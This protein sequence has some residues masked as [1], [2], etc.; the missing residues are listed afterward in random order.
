[1]SLPI[2]ARGARPRAIACAGAIVLALSYLG[3]ASAQEPSSGA[4]GGG[5]AS[6]DASLALRAG[7]PGIGVE[8]AKLL[9]DHLAVR[10]GFNFFR[11]TASQEQTD[12]SY[13]ASATLHGVTALVDVYP[14]RRAAFHLTGGI[15][16]N[17]LTV[18]AT[19]RPTSSGDYT[20]NGVS[21]P[22]SQVGTLT[23]RATY[24]AV[25]P[26]VGLGFGTPARGAGRIGLLV[27]LGAVIGQPRIALAATGAAA[28]PSFAADL[29]AQ[30]TTTEHDVDRYAKVFPVL[31]LGLA[32]RF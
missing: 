30:R 2:A 17:P 14:G 8:A 27:D 13:D 26:Y 10:A 12:V 19:G 15:M 22:A 5:A 3:S 21:Y 24:P 9:T 29:E 28:D 4:S 11:L 18:K 31:S 16:T 1:M 25:A 7:T 32:V 20:I 6:L 23:A